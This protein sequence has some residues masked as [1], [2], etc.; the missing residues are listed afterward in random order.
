ML[1]NIFTSSFILS[2]LLLLSSTANA[3]PSYA[4]QTGENCVACHTS[5]PE[6]TPFG[7][8]FKL[9]GYT[10]GEAQWL[11]LAVMM[12][13]STTS[14]SKPKDNSA[15]VVSSKQ[16]TVQFDYASLFL[17]GKVNDHLG[18]FI[19]YTY[20]NDG[21]Q[22]T[23]GSNIHHSQMDNTDIRIIEKYTLFDKSLV[24]GGTLNNNPTVQDV[25]NTTPAWGYP[26]NGPN[27]GLPGPSYTTMIDGGLAQ[28]V[29]GLGAYFWW[30]R[31]LY[32]E[33]SFYGTANKL[34]RP[35]SAGQAW[36]TGGV[37][38][39]NGRN[40]PYWRLAW[41]QEWGASSWMIGTYGMQVDAYPTGLNS[42][43]TDRYTD[44]AFDTQYQYISDPSVYSLQSTIIHENQK[45]GATTASN[46]SDNLNTFKIKG[47]YLYDR[48]YGASLA[49]VNTFGSR[50][51]LLYAT[52]TDVN[53]GKAVSNKPDSAYY[54]AQLDYDPK[55][56]M[57]FSLQYR[58]YMKLDGASSNVDGNGRSAS[59]DNT[60]S[61]IAWFAY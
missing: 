1:K 55:P 59:D 19:Q 32:G 12:Q 28:Q 45:W 6:L 8:E 42:G 2:L 9:N 29:V 21:D 52:V 46:S 10:L 56:N 33:L 20:S 47:S 49:Y 14:L 38:Q 61:L 34:F 13:A 25:W 60:L 3:V 54:V 36:D 17:A 30:D 7:R 11:P 43:A 40:N 18:A 57:R 51:D 26:Y 15:N 37:T 23:D 16:S 50:D 44:I 58:A 27:I 41:N 4:R 48:K 22:K 5:F 35:L 39:L 31:H 24:I 53:T